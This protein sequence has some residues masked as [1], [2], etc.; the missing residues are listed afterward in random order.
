MNG[1]S[2]DHNLNKSERKE[3]FCNYFYPIYVLEDY[4]LYSKDI[5][6]M[7]RVNRYQLQEIVVVY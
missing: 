4:N 6:K 7:K 3:V 5:F 1:I 2:S